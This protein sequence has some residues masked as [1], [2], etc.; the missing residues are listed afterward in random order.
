MSD[1]EGENED[2]VNNEEEKKGDDN[3]VDEENKE[4]KPASPTKAES[5]EEKIF[6]RVIKIKPKE[7]LKGIRKAILEEMGV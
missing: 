7:K 6:D 4:D 2:D 1:N 3:A 5:P